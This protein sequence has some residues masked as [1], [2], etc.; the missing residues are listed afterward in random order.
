MGGFSA[1]SSSS[2]SLSSVSTSASFISIISLLCRCEGM[3]SCSVKRLRSSS[4]DMC[5]V[6]M[7]SF[8][9]MPESPSLDSCRSKTFSSIEPAQSMR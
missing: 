1:A 7:S 6:S 5:A 8:V 2:S 4:R 3:L 9:A